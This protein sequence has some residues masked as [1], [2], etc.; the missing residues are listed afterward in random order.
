MVVVVLDLPANL[1]GLP[2]CGV[3]VGVGRTRPDGIQHLGELP[4]ANSHAGRARPDIRRDG[5]AGDGSC[6]RGARLGSRAGPRRCVAEIGAEKI[7]I[8]PLSARAPK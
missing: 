1:A 5:S 4:G 8:G 2:L 7:T 6:G 3:D